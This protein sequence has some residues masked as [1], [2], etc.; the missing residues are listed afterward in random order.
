[1][2]ELDTGRNNIKETTIKVTGPTGIKFRMQD[3]EVL[4]D[5]MEENSKEPLL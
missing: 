2:L 5:S 4:S 1:M 3:S